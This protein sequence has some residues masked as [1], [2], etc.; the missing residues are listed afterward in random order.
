MIFSPAPIGSMRAHSVASVSHAS[1]SPPAPS[2]VPAADFD[3][4][5]V[6]EPAGIEGEHGHSDR[7]R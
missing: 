6:R 1:V 7:I 3:G 5:P 4:D 2:G